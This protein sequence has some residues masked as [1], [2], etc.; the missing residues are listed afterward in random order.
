MLAVSFRAKDTGTTPLREIEGEFRNALLDYELRRQVDAQTGRVRD[1][2]VAKAVA[3]A[4][5]LDDPPPGTGNDPVD[6]RR[7]VQLAGQS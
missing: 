5:T 2:L 6:D 7:L 1:L 4:G 3:E